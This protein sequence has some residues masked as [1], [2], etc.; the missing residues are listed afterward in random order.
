MVEIHAGA[1]RGLREAFR[2]PRDRCNLGFN[3][4]AFQRRN[5]EAVPDTGPDVNVRCRQLRG[6]NF[7]DPVSGRRGAA[8]AAG[9][10]GTD[11][12]TGRALSLA[13]GTP[14]AGAAMEP[15]A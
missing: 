2:M 4:G 14:A 11:A 9:V 3:P 10:P 5:L 1:G 15:V 13:A 7:G 6:D 12:K 8:A